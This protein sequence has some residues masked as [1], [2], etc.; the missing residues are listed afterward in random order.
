[1]ASVTFHK[2]V[3]ANEVVRHLVTDADGIYIDGTLGGG[4]HSASL[5]NALS[6]KGRL[7]AF[8]QDDDALAYT[9]PKF[10]K[11]PRMKIIRGNFAYMDVLL[12]AEVQGTA[13]GVLFDLGVSSHQIDEP[14]RGFSYLKEGPL[15]MRMG[16]FQALTAADIVNQMEYKDLRNLLF[17]YGEERQSARIAKKIVDERP[18]ATTTDLRNVVA[19]CVP[20]RYL[21]KSLARVFQALRIEVNKELKMLEKGLE[22]GLEM[23]REG[24]RFAVITYH[25]LEDRICKYFFRSGRADGVLMKDF[26]GN[27]LSPMRM[28]HKGVITADKA[29]CEA[30]PRARS[31]KLRIAVKQTCDVP[32]IPSDEKGRKL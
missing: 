7:Y 8:D 1:M 11:E 30:N 17:L 23:L 22:K 16:S 20:S 10:S 5:L 29:A 32:S 14:E 21:N 25:S 4:G 2:P 28:L 24:G 31:A 3:L 6:A 15:D 26:Y 9:T 18:L 13:S 27:D 19:S 12:P